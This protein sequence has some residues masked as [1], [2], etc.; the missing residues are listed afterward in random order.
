[1]WPR[2]QK[3]SIRNLIKA[4][5]CLGLLAPAVSHSSS[6]TPAPP[7]PKDKKAEAERY[8][9]QSDA[10]KAAQEASSYL[11]SYIQNY[12]HFGVARGDRD[13]LLKRTHESI[14][15]CL[16]G[17]SACTDE[18]KIEVMNAL[19]QYNLGKDLRRMMLENSTNFENIKS[20]KGA[21]PIHSLK[22]RTTT[23]EPFKL[24]EEDVAAATTFILDSKKMQER[25]ILGPTFLNE[26]RSFLS[27]YSNTTPDR[28][29]W[30]YVAQKLPGEE[31]WVYARGQDGKPLVDEERF[32]NDQL[33][34]R[35]KTIQEAAKFV[36]K[37]IT[38]PKLK[39]VNADTFRAE[40]DIDSD[41]MTEKLGLKMY[42][43]LNTDTGKV[44]ND[45]QS[46]VAY[47]RRING[48]VEEAQKRKKPA[49]GVKV[50]TTYTIDPDAFRNFLDE[51]W[52]PSVGK[53]KPGS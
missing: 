35:D 40:S 28:K 24:K 46:A 22:G 23:P 43:V 20:M 17:S 19:V 38:E 53:I 5:V 44:L 30:H 12:G 1:M 4:V 8:L 34:Q 9:P 18:R 32:R 39:K 52:P 10:F 42:P 14:Q 11:G 48:V 2:P 6:R 36:Q 29:D 16:Q 33:S 47:V 25:D 3:R 21:Q 26:Y 13:K 7:N 51:I 45:E 50:V 37:S 31:M 27:E 41:L 49:D 15:L